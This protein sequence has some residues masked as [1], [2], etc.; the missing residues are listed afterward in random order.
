MALQP[1]ALSKF[2]EMYKLT[3][4]EVL[5]PERIYECAVKYH[6]VRG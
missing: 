1:E 5:T 3:S 6:E 4:R 2:E